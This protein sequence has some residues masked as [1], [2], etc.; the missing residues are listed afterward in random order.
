MK[1][2]ALSCQN[3]ELTDYFLHCCDLAPNNIFQTIKTKTT[4]SPIFHANFKT[5]NVF[6]R[7]LNRNG[8]K[9]VGELV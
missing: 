8:K 2:H 1:H 3:M 6:S 5:V 4:K 7:Y 9:V